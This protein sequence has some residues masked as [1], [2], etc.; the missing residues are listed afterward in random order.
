MSLA[1]VGALVPKIS[2][3]VHLHVG[4][5]VAQIPMGSGVHSQLL[6]SENPTVHRNNHLLEEKVVCVV[7]SFTLDSYLVS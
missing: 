2:N 4:A 3:P 5:K 6:D 7:C 1:I